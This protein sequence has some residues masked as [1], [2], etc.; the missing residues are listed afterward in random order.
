MKTILII[1][2]DVYISNMLEEVL[3]KEGYGVIHA[4]SGTEALMLLSQK[5]I[6]QVEN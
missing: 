2:D 3:L 4:Y 6:N 1:D 5:F